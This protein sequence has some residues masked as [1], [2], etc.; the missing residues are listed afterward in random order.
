[1]VSKSTTTIS[2]WSSLNNELICYLQVAAVEI[3]LPAMYT[4]EANYNAKYSAI[5]YSYLLPLGRLRLLALTVNLPSTISSADTEAVRKAAIK[6]ALTWQKD[7]LSESN[8][9]KNA[10][11]KNDSKITSYYVLTFDIQISEIE[12]DISN[13]DIGHFDNNSYK[14]EASQRLTHHFGIGYFKEE[15]VLDSSDRAQQLQVFSWQDW[16]L[17]LTTL[18]TPCELWRYFG[19]YLRHLESSVTT[20]ASE[21]DSEQILLTKFMSS[22]ALF[23][24]AISVD[25]A[26]IKYGMQDKPNSA[27]VTMTLAQRSNSVTGL[28]YLQHMQQAATVWSQL[29]TQMLYLASE[30]VTAKVEDEDNKEELSALQSLHWWQQLTD[31]S[32]FSRHELVRTLYRHPKQP[33]ALQQSGYVVH[34]HSYESLGRHYVLIF[35]GQASIGQHSK[36]V[37]QPNLQK[38]A[39]DVATRLPMAELHHIMVLGIEFIADAKDT[40]MDIDLWIQPV[41]AM[42]Q[43]ERQLTKKIQRLE[44][45]EVD[46]QS[47]RYIQAKGEKNK[48]SNG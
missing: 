36:A 37:I 16:Q 24:Q 30:K 32:L 17:I 39:Q 23:A 27:L 11:Q 8:N 28:V 35:Y 20:N 4:V 31:E 9:K 3:V 7:D 34:Q 19:Y 15:L 25:N 2:D 46:Q 29:S 38:I 45:Q 5:L 13:V 22:E 10:Y 1:M 6:S 18:Q 42:T 47:S 26:L 40:F 12:A 41:N 48:Q 44:Q 43:R 21:F 33:L 14:N